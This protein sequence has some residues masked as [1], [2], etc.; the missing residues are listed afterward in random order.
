MRITCTIHSLDGG[1]AERLMAG[2]AS[3][4]CETDQV[5]LVTLDRPGHDR[6]PLD[7]RV[8]RVAL[9]LLGESRSAGIAIRNNMRRLRA[10][11]RGLAASRPDVILS[12]CDLHN[13]L[14]L[15]AAAS[16]LPNPIAPV[17]VSEH[18]DPRHQPLGPFWGP[19]RRRL[20]RRAAAAIAL[21]EPV[22]AILEQWC[23]SPIHIIPPAIDTPAPDSSAPRPGSIEASPFRW[24]WLGRL[25]KEKGLDRALRAFAQASLEHPDS[26]LIVAGT[27]PQEAALRHL[28]ASLDIAD[29]VEWLGWVAE[30]GPLLG[31]C[32]GFLLTSHYEGF[33]LGLLEAMAAG[34]VCVAMDIESG[35]SEVIVD[36]QNGVL[37]PAG[38]TAAV[39][40]AM[41]E[42]MAD[43][44]R[45]AVLAEAARTV[46]GRFSWEAYTGAH[47]RLLA[48]AAEGPPL[49]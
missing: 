40:A 33:P 45:A 37:V 20:Y 5:T 25:S 18:S 10:M 38:D 35:P 16:R 1:G 22:A 24:L 41:R 8:R 39:A 7:P 49:A 6:Y 32:D 21:T 26:R 30:V 29:R 42:M 14:T 28:A 34:L 4:L 44:P 17:V 31:R 27:G 3:R 36:G 12:F 43:R 19:L 46:A 13:T 48:Q 15:A 11:R 23:P 9:G 47:R 2:L